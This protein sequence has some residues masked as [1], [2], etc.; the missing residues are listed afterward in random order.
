MPPSSPALAEPPPARRGWS[1]A[2]AAAAILSGGAACGAPPT[3]GPACDPP[4]G[5]ALGQLDDATARSGVRFTY[6]TLGFQGGGLAAVDLDGDDLPEIVAGRRDGGVSVF[7]NRGGLR[8]QEDLDSGIPAAAAARAIG[9]AD[10]DNDGDRDLVLAAA[11]SALVLTN[12]GDGRFTEWVRLPSTGATE[13]VLP[14]DLDGDGRLDLYFSN[15]DVRSADASRNRLYLGRAPDQLVPAPAPGAG[16]SWAATAHDFDEDGDQDLYVAN[17]TL[18]A[19]FGTGAAQPRP[20]WPV[21]LFL[22][23]DGPSP[24]G[25]RL[26]DV[27]SAVGLAAPRSSMGGVLGD[28]DRDG[29]LDLYVPDYGAKKLFARPGSE[30]MA[31]F[32]DRAPDLG[33]TATA[34]ASAACQGDPVRED[35]L[36]LSWSAAIADLDLDGWDEVLL[37]NGETAPGDA[38]PVVLLARGAGA[39]Y[40][41]A[42]TAIPCIDARG[43]VATDL[44]GDGDPD[45]AIAP[46]AGPLVVYERRGRPPAGSWLRVTLR[47]RASNRDGIGAVVTAHLA[48]G[49]SLV[50]AV[51]AGGVVHSAAPAEAAF[52]LGRERATAIEVRWPAGRRT[53]TLPA[54][55]DAAL[56]GPLVID[57]DRP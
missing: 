35:C 43:L 37:V 18:V 33:L 52:G 41:E 20:R 21:D 45:L 32:V 48:S 40:R 44:D 38:P 1:I 42:S 24:E 7:R 56:A 23:N 6:A 55:P 29:R 54:E 49:R 9:A 46:P 3:T 36:V 17:D 16:L 30:A 53:V 47:G 10:L 50:R 11:D 26:T 14:A 31:A 15:Y 2:A 12:T 51:G 22:R 13:H 57:E 34:R 19:D 27:A 5:P 25:P 28:L 4:R 8:F 39:E